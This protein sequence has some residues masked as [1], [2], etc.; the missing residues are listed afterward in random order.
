[1]ADQETKGSNGSG[2]ES[3]PPAGKAPLQAAKLQAA[4]RPV[5]AKP[6]VP[7]KP[8]AG[9]AVA[10]KPV[11]MEADVPEMKR[12]LLKRTETRSTKWFQIFDADK[13]DDEQV[14]GGHLALL[15]TLGI[16][17]GIY[18]ISG[19]QVNPFSG[20]PGF[21]DNWFYL[22]IKPRLVSLG[23]DTY[24]QTQEALA[25][26]A[27]N[28]VWWAGIHFAVG[29]LLI[30][31]GWRHWTHN[32]YNPFTK[33]TGRFRDFNFA[34]IAGRSAK[35]Y[36]EA[37]GA[38]VIYLAFIFLAWGGVMWGVLGNAP[39]TDFHTI[40]SETLMSFFWGFVL[41]GLG[42]YLWANPPRAA[43][44]LNDDLKAIFSVHMTAIGYI[45]I[46]LGVFAFVAFRHPEFYYKQLDDLVFYLYG[47]PFNRVRHGIVEDPNFP[48]FAILP[49]SGKSYGM[50]QVVINLLAFNH[51]IMGTLYLFGGVF[52][53][54]QYML[55][56]QMSGV[57]SQIKSKWVALGRDKETQVKFL[58]TVMVICF[59]TMSS[60]YAVVCW[61]SICELNVFGTNISMSF[62]WLKPL[63][64]FHWMFTD[65]SIND[66]CATHEIVAGFTFCLVALVRIAF[67]SHTS[68]LWEDLGLKKNS[69]SFPCL[70]P[71]YGGTCGVSIQDQLWFA[72]LW[73]I[74]GLSVF[75]WYIDG[76]WVASMN[77]GMSVADCNMWDTIA[78]LKNHFTGGVFYYMWTETN[79][80]WAS[81]HLTVVL[82][83]GHLTWFVSFAVWFKDRG[84]R[85]EGAD[86]QTRTIRWLGKT[87]LKRDVKFRFPVL[88]LSDSK[89]A[90][91]VLYYSGTF[92][93]V[94]L[95][96]VNGFYE[97]N[98][99]I[100]VMHRTAQSSSDMLAAVMDYV[101]KL[102]T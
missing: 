43:E 66:W 3:K 85:L 1:M 82:L 37:W 11:I 59:A 97:T 29:S 6:A 54:G 8:A 36:A 81:S 69:F 72:M 101:V 20:G 75:E 38:H 41:L 68:P 89:F 21:H 67:F 17:M 91:T 76:G 7:A 39:S 80:I 32:M 22:V 52:A 71:V 83:L 55:R 5:G 26:A 61:N 30:F 16:V 46:A 64:P 31:G 56:I 79:A 70:G 47:E 42:F 28:L 63:P 65:P 14:V 84:S 27:H 35:N 2:G 19:L 44:H 74:K 24:T 86:I 78:G 50:S 94:W 40:N 53:G 98:E 77:Y 10:E 45:N 49:K 9:V 88:N 34:W 33:K 95:Y 15:G 4:A 25:K 96:V 92:I 60:V 12:F 99:P 62:Y 100:V 102:I 13:L 73:S 90:G 23:I 58:G 93:L 18:Y 87:F 51:V 48:A 57:Y